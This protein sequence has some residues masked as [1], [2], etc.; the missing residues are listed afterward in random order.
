MKIKV[1][2]LRSNFVQSARVALQNAIYQF[3]ALG[4]P[5]DSVYKEFDEQIS[6][7]SED[8]DITKEDVVKDVSEVVSE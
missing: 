2:D 5:L 7:I 4:Y 8:I 6:N 3:V 1:S